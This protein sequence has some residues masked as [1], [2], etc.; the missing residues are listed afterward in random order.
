MVLLKEMDSRKPVGRIYVDQALR[1]E[2]QLLQSR[3]PDAYAYTASA[4]TITAGSASFTLPSAS[5][6]EYAGDI[7]IQLQSD[8]SFLTKLHQDE[9]QRFRDGSSTTSTGRPRFFSP[10][11]EDDQQV[12]CWVY[13]VA[14]STETYNLFRSI[15]AADFSTT[16]IAGATLMLSREGQLA[17]IYETATAIASA[18][19]KED[20]AQRRLNPSIVADWHQ[21]AELA[22]YQEGDRRASIEGVGRTMRFES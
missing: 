14:T 22:L 18:M 15:V 9:M 12:A 7:R 19:T 21:K 13:P 4:G 20:L 8:N 17:L 2:Y 6:A 10:Y 1:N 3:L 5:S 16:D 11:E